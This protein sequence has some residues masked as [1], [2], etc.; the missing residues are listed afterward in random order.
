[1]ALARGAPE[2]EHLVSGGKVIQLVPETAPS[3]VSEE[4]VKMLEQ[5]LEKAKAGEFNGFACITVTADN[6][7][8]YT[9][10]GTMWAG[11]GVT[12]NSH[13][14]VGGVEVL[15]KRMLDELFVWSK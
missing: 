13:T 6:C 15:K 10:L 9:A 1:M 5:L 7:G 11:N 3:P 8:H 12:Q 14:A 2:V 4:C